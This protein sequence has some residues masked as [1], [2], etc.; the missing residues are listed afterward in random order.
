MTYQRAAYMDH[1]HP[2]AF[3]DWTRMEPKYGNTKECPRCKGWGGWNLE[4]NAYKLPPNT[5]DTQENRHKFVHFRAMCNHCNGWG[6]VSPKEKCPGH[7]WVFAENLGN[8]YNRYTCSVCGMKN[9][10]DSSG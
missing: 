5:P 8:C 2:D 10:V 6:Y 7:E 1:T 9:D 3:V 4:M